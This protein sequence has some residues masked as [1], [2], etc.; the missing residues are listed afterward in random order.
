MT[1]YN[2]HSD[3]LM[4]INRESNLLATLQAAI[5]EYTTNREDIS[6]EGIKIYNRLK[7]IGKMALNQHSELHNEGR[8]LARF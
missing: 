6:S 3:R 2:I 5:D 1:A 8:K 4:A 7:D